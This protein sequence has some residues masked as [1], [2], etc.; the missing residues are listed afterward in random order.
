MKVKRLGLNHRGEACD[1]KPITCSEGFCEDC[2][3][4]TDYK[5]HQRTMG[6]IA[7]LKYYETERVDKLA[8]LQPEW[9][10]EYEKEQMSLVL[11]LKLQVT[12][13]RKEAFA[14]SAYGSKIHNFKSSARVDAYDVVLGLIEKALG[15]K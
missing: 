10:R 2:Q 9:L 13:K 15:G 4:Y 11:L 5:G 6:G 3:I 14:E 7:S 8:S 1:I 12:Q